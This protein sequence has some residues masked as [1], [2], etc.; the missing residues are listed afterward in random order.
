[1]QEQKDEWGKE[2]PK[3]VPDIHV[4]PKP[5]IQVGSCLPFGLTMLLVPGPVSYY[6]AS[7]QGKESPS[8]PELQLACYSSLVCGCPTQLM[9]GS[10]TLLGFDCHF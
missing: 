10:A 7:R 9:D 3:A 6:E 2:A 5:P 1:M 4:L 8:L